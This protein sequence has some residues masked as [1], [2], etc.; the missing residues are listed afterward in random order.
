M[1]DISERKRTEDELRM[2]EER[3]H[4]LVEHSQ[5]AITVHDGTKYLYAKE[6]AIQ[7]HGAE[8]RENLIARDPMEF[9]HP[10]EREEVLQ[11]RILVL[12][13]GLT[14]HITEQKR[15]CLDGSQITVECTGNPVN[16][17]GRDCILVEARDITARHRAENDLLV[18]KESA[19]LAN[20]TK[21]EFLANMSH[22]L[23]TPLNAV[24]GFSEIMKSELL[25]KSTMINTRIIATIFTK[26]EFIF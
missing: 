8:T 11:R 15:L 1:R 12:E 16:W 17:N 21:T 24:I 5:A 6:A 4:E 7:L 2:S 3:Y 9:I 19:K 10:D 18:A 20:R 22:E 23:R 25:G 13:H 26:A 14:A